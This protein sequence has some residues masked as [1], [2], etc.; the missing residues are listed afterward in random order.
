VHRLSGLE[1]LS[2]RGSETGSANPISRQPR[3][4]RTRWQG[5]SFPKSSGRSSSR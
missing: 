5:R 3:K 1:P 4:G 2:K